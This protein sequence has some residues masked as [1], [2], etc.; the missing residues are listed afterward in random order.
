MRCCI[1][2]S[3]SN[4]ASI[5]PSEGRYNSC[6]YNRRQKI[7]SYRQYRYSK[8]LHSFLRQLFTFA[9]KKKKV[10]SV[11]RMKKNRDGRYDAVHYTSLYG[12]LDAVTN[13]AA[14]QQHGI[15]VSTSFDCSSIVWD[16]NRMRHVHTLQHRE[17]ASLLY[18]N[19]ATV[20]FYCLFLSFARLMFLSFF[21]LRVT[22]L[23]AYMTI[24]LYGA[25]TVGQA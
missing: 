16:L 7:Y 1:F 5:L 3:D 4:H 19:E 20:S 23:H 13:I 15:A 22:L 17:P 21:L 10:V 18:I 24:L 2:W 14:S 9:K 25:S 11:F 6:L 12:H 8:C